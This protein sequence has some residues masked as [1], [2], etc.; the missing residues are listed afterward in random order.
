MSANTL[1]LHTHK[2]LMCHFYSHDSSQRMVVV[3]L[4]TQ[5]LE[6]VT[7]EVPRNKTQHP[8]EVFEGPRIKRSPN[9]RN[10]Q[11]GW[12]A[13]FQER[14]DNFG[15]FT[16]LQNKF[17]GMN[18]TKCENQGKTKSPLTVL[19]DF[20]AESNKRHT[21]TNLANLYKR[22]QIFTLVFTTTEPRLLKHFTWPGGTN[23][24][25]GAQIH[26]SVHTRRQTQQD[27]TGP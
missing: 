18:D 24:A 25:T 16:L 11:S 9:K 5:T 27:T 26:F 8:Y 3:C 12:S 20:S 19:V 22:L 15:V 1:S 10:F 23:L 13:Y 17:G 14:D 7:T 4:N 2:T 6:K 21:T